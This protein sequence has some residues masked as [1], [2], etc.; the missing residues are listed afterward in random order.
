MP[1]RGAAPEPCAAHGI[2]ETLRTYRGEP[3]ALDDHV[4][5]LWAS[6]RTLG[7][8]MPATRRAVIQRLQRLARRGQ[9]RDR[10]LRVA[11]LPAHPQARLVYLSRP[12]PRH[13]ASW[14]TGGID[15]WTV[16]SARL[17]VAAV[18]PQVKHSN[19]LALILAQLDLP[20]PLP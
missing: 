7:L 4:E 1:D 3:F 19:R 9:G 17:T 16:P 2:F 12:L 11:V 5:R 8:A 15:L 10:L 18:N 20:A 14:Y 6:A 13:P